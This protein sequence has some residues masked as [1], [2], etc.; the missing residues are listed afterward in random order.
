MCAC[1]ASRCTACDP[2]A[3]AIATKFGSRCKKSS[4]CGDHAPPT[5]A[6]LAA[7]HTC[8][9][10]GVGGW[11]QQGAQLDRDLWTCEQGVCLSPKATLYITCNKQIV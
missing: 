11:A 2:Q 7:K 9:G 10:Q 6:A 1:K 8:V 3:L 5:A 4:D